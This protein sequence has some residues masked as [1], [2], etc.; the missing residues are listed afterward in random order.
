M[1]TSPTL[2]QPIRCLGLCAVGLLACAPAPAEPPREPVQSIQPLLVAA[3]ARGHA[4]GILV[5]PAAD[6]IAG[7]FASRAPIVV[8]VTAV[9][10]LATLGCKRLQVETRQ[11][12]VV[13]RDQSTEPGQ[14]GRPLPARNLRL[15]YRISFCADGSFP[16]SASAAARGR[17]RS[18]EAAR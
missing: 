7:Q 16:P 18:P 4:Q 1:L 3:I 11:K 15:Q 2:L 8:E 13:D 10:D 14:A 12:Q 17:P 5:G 9:A 6:A